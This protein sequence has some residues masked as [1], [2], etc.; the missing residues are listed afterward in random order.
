MLDS[1]ESRKEVIRPDFNRAIRIDFFS[2][3]YVLFCYLREEL[4]SRRGPVGRFYSGK[5][6]PKSLWGRTIPLYS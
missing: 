4:V 6:A 3:N 2:P 5:E 1:G